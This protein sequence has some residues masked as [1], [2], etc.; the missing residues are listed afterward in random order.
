MLNLRKITGDFFRSAR[1]VFDANSE[2]DQRKRLA[3]GQARMYQ[4]QQ[5]QLQAQ[6]V[7]QLQRQTQQIQNTVRN[8]IGAA[9][10]VAKPTIN[11]YFKPS[12]D[13]VRARDIV[14]ETGG[15]LGQAANA[16]TENTQRLV[17]TADAPLKSLEI[18]AAYKRGEIG[19]DEARKRA[20]AEAAQGFIPLKQNNKGELFDK[21]S[22]PSKSLAQK[23][24]E[25]TK[26]FA[27]AGA[28]TASEV[29]PFARGASNTY[30][31]MKLAK[32]AV[33]ILKEGSVYGA[34]NAG[35]G[36]AENGFDPKRVAT[37]YATGVG[38]EFLGYGAGKLLDRGG[39]AL[40]NQT[41]TGTY[42]KGPDGK[43]TGSTKKVKDPVQAEADRLAAE[44]MS[45]QVSVLQKQVANNPAPA[46][47]K[48]YNDAIKLQQKLLNGDR[49][50]VNETNALYEAGLKT[51]KAANATEVPL[52]KAPRTKPT[53]KDAITTEQGPV[54]Q[55]EIQRLM[56]QSAD[57]FKNRNVDVPAPRVEITGKA[58]KDPRVQ[59]V[60]QSISRGRSNVDA[61]LVTADI[62]AAAKK[63]GVKLDQGFID[64]Y[65]AGK[66]LSNEKGV[67][68]K[69]KEVTDKIF[70]QQKK[71]DPNIEYRKNYVPQVYAQADNIVEDAARKLQTATGAA[72]PRAFNS[73]QEARAFGLTPKYSSLDQIIG[74]NASAASRSLVNRQ[75]IEKGLKSGIFD[76]YPDKGWAPV[77]GFMD[78]QGNQIF[79]QK[80]VADAL[81]GVTQTGTGGLEKTLSTTAKLS[82]KAQDIMLQGGIPGTNFNFFT[83]G[84]GVKDT[85][86]NIGKA[87]MLRPDQAV[88]QE[89][90]LI[91][92]FF[93]GKNGTIKRF[94]KPENQA[95]V[96]EMAD[97]G[98]YINPQTSISSVGK[99]T[100]EKGWDWLGNNPT[101]GRYMPN[102]LLSTAQ[103]VYSQSVNKLGHQ[104]ALDLAAETTKRF[105]GHVDQIM[106]GR[107]NLSADAITSVAFAPKYRES[108]ITALN[109]VAKSVY[110]KNWADKTYAPSRQLLAGMA[111]TLAGYEA[112]NQQ[113]T[114]HSMFEN[115][116]GQELSLEIPYGEKDAKGNQKVVNIPFMPGF[117][118]IPRALVG[119]AQSTLRGDV[120]GVIAEA[121]KF[122]SA[123]LQTAGRVLA[124]QDYFGRP[125]YIDQATADKEGIAPDSG[126]AALGK[127]GAY[128]GGQFSPAWVRA[129]LDAAQGKPKEQAIATALEAPVRFGK[130]NPEQTAYFES[131]DAFYK[132]LNKNEKTLFDKMNPQKKNSRGELIQADRLP[133]AST[134][135]YGDLVANPE[136]AAKYQAYKASQPNHD[137]LW[138]LSPNQL[139]SYM[140][141]QVI[142]KNDPGGD[143]T[144]VRKLY[145]RLPDDFFDKRGAY[146]EQLK[147]KG[148]L[149]KDDPN[150]TPRP[151]MPKELEAFA[152]TYHN[153]PY[154]TGA[155]SKALRTAE[156]QAYLAYLDANKL[157][158]NQERA[159]LGLPP[160]EDSSYASKGG[161]SGGRS[162]GG[163]KAKVVNPDKYRISEKAKGKVTKAKFAKGKALVKVK[164]SSPK[165]AKAK[166]STTR[167]RV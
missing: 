131:K 50:S 130:V 113:I 158:N 139:R 140:Q 62:Q 122:A 73:Y 102:R 27:V 45:P 111:A 96:K 132:T 3:A 145:A 71:L 118:T 160:L 142:S 64:R 136:F 16:V 63:A 41:P 14:R 164:T 107:S 82:G 117:M 127:V 46:N 94:A 84:Q 60:L 5:K 52:Q 147:A 138:D 95:F 66:V 116:K 65:Q 75:A 101:F 67:A 9:Y 47:K 163:G 153:L 44:A 89:I 161:S 59:E 124:N 150:Y 83:F 61:N 77:T 88:K 54:S 42:T 33:P 21:Y 105:T 114:G 110:P 125:I 97:R 135:N 68:A 25:F 29:A 128:V 80:S 35:V 17:Q 56:K 53:V 38:S 141:A 165:L 159:D 109:N 86:R 51:P 28:K 166:T 106:K 99:G 167:S 24:G 119:A 55:K 104:G 49:L 154:G 39:K 76:V 157:Y 22:D 32:A 90:N 72:N 121:S 40:A 120:P 91:G 18:N 144:T 87:I 34:L 156:G 155:R 31:G 126:A 81:N 134:A 162:G 69:I 137:P 152:D 129:G 36:V 43:L 151:K 13:K 2:E 103:E 108:I 8:P 11:N 123:P 1:D 15:L 57:E 48:A 23:T 143:S 93:R 98:L 148:V 133:L 115:R 7:Q 70:E 146:F 30:R 12:A 20:Q 26:D 58:A 6:R 85:T 4:D 149:P 10:N 37:D 74:T 19:L 78:N 112:L 100:L 92:D 79:A